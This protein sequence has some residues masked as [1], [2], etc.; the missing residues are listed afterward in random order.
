MST[1]IIEILQFL[2]RCYMS[3]EQKRG[4]GRPLVYSHASMTLFFMVMTLKGI[5]SFQG[6]TKYAKAHY[7]DF[8]FG[9]APLVPDCFPF[10]QLKERRR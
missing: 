3:Y 7:Q 9:S 10:L 6:M 8:G 1:K 2:Q 4:K 5:Y